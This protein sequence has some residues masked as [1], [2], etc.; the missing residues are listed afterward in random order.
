MFHSCT[1]LKDGSV[2]VF[3]GR[4]APTRPCTD[5]GIFK[6]NTECFNRN[7]EYGHNND[8]KTI[9]WSWKADLTE[10]NLPCDTERLEMEIPCA[11]WRH[12]ATAVDIKG[13]ENVLIFGGI[14]KQRQVL[15]DGWLFNTTT[16]RWK[17]VLL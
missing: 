1:T 13:Q 6:I 2:F 10:T 4:G 15:S 16:Q 17:K 12:T 3:G 9:H 5:Y 11:R 8:N 7:E 14:D